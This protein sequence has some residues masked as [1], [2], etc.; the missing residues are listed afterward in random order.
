G[1]EAARRVRLIRC[2]LPL[3]SFPFDARAGRHPGEPPLIVSVGRLVDYKG[4]DVLIRACAILKKGGR[5]VRCLIA[6]EGPE[7]SRLSG[8]VDDLSLEADVTFTGGCRQ[9]AV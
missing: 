1:P 2:G 5:P 7:R 4:F 6:G 3:E 8:L 9:E